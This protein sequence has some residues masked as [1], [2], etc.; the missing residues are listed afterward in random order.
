MAAILGEVAADFR[1]FGDLAD[2]ASLTTECAL[3]VSLP[4]MMLRGYFKGLA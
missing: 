2:L 4:C 3:K 1:W